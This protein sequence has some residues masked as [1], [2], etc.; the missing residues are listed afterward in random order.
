MSCGAVSAWASCNPNGSVYIPAG[1]S[2]T[3]SVVYTTGAAL[4][5]IR[6]VASVTGTTANVSDGNSSNNTATFNTTV[7]D[8]P[9]EKWCTFKS[10]SMI[11]VTY[12]RDW[13]SSKI[14]P[15]TVSEAPYWSTCRSS[16]CW[17]AT[18]VA[19]ADSENKWWWRG[20]NKPVTDASGKQMQMTQSTFSYRMLPAFWPRVVSASNPAAL[21]FM[22]TRHNPS[23]EGGAL[24]KAPSSSQNQA[25][26]PF[27]RD[28]VCENIVPNQVITFA[29][30]WIPYHGERHLEGYRATTSGNGMT[31]VWRE[32]SGGPSCGSSLATRIK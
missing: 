8:I 3:Y 24:F 10:G 7:K 32:Y 9:I 31:V 22:D 17:Y 19:Y 12:G 23:A 25:M 26:T 13:Q 6:L 28:G 21:Q 27:C 4:G 30:T 2:V 20:T 14:R 1:G 15:Y 29:A 16:A 5:Q 11:S 18:L